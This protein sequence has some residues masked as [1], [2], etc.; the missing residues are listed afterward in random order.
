M[1]VSATR[2]ASCGR[3][4]FLQHS[5]VRVNTMDRIVRVFI[6]Y[7]EDES[8]SSFYLFFFLFGQSSAS[9]WCLRS[10]KLNCRSKG[11]VLL[12]QYSQ[13]QEI[14]SSSRFQGINYCYVFFFFL[15]HLKIFDCQCLSFASSVLIHLSFT[16]YADQNFANVCLGWKVIGSRYKNESFRSSHLRV[17]SWFP[18]FLVVEHILYCIW[19]LL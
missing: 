19:N 17:Y 13:A 18:L 7:P 4:P 1:A 16:I 8:G 6:F 3:L 2:V 15:L 12:A 10:K 9:T 5:Q 11:L 14:F